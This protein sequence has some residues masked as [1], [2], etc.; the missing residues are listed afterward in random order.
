[1]TKQDALTG[2]MLNP[3]QQDVIVNEESVYQNQVVL[4]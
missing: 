4:Y 1:M 3:S 2:N